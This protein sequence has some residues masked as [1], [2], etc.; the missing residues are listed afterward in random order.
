MVSE[1]AVV[2]IPEEAEIIIPLLRAGRSNPRVH[3]LTYSA[4][5][6]QKMLVFKDWNFYSIPAL[7]ANWKAP[8]PLAAQLAVFA[9]ALYFTYDD[10]A[11][12]KIHLG[13][14]E[15]DPPVAEMERLTLDQNAVGSKDTSRQV[16]NEP[17][18]R[19]FTANP[20][21]FLHEWLAIRRQGQDCAHTPMGSVVQ[22]KELS[23]RHPFFV[24][25]TC[26]EFVA[27]APAPADSNPMQDYDE[28]QDDH[29]EDHPDD[30][31][32]PAH[33]HYDHEDSEDE[34]G[35]AADGELSGDDETGHAV[36]KP[37]PG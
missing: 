1:T 11:E 14:H 33:E 17:A 3:L 7:P 30:Y 36:A 32:D 20:L 19:P 26:H 5:V 10:Y 16:M 22:G 34:N 9:G 35:K 6:T 8:G 31:G 12:L 25:S 37:I 2:V 18:R 15:S 21:A 28:G 13:V 24:D 29:Y 27:L 4:P 23:A